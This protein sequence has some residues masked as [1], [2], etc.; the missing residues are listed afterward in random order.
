MQTQNSE[1]Y[2]H[3]SENNKTQYLKTSEEIESQNTKID[4]IHMLCVKM[5]EHTSKTP[6]GE[7]ALSKGYLTEEQLNECLELQKKKIT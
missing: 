4:A 1:A 6:I 5:Y 3:I 7:I 2:K